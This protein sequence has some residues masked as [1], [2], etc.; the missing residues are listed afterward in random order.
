M[1]LEKIEKCPLCNGSDFR[2]K[3]TCTD[4]TTTKKEF[5]LVQCSTCNFILTN[6]R[7]D[8]EGIGVYYKSE[9]YISHTGG[10]KNLLDKIYVITRYF[11]LKKKRKIIETSSQSRSLLDYGCGTGEFI[12]VCKVS[13]WAV[14]G[15][16]PSLEARN[17]ARKLNDTKIYANISEVTDCQ[18]DAITLWHVLEHVHEL[19]NTLEN[20]V[21][22]LKPNGTIFIAVPNHESWDAIHYRDHWAAYD[23]PRH[24]WHFSKDNMDMLL[25]KYEMKLSKILPMKLDAYYVS[26]LSEKYQNPN[27]ASFKRYLNG[28]ING[29]KSN[30]N[31]RGKN[32]YSSLIYVFKR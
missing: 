22:L 25:S 2:F 18:F 1:A 15:I 31:A 28:F 23:V 3:L 10:Y 4:F 5:R 21:K 26:L 16:E 13:G 7:P 6:P 32:N 20:L 24:L 19:R 8:S 27:Q 14:T 30:I 17:K 12:K 11:S 29:L 9:S